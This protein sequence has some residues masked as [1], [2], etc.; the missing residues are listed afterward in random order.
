MVGE[1]GHSKSLAAAAM[2]CQGNGK[3]ANGWAW[4]GVQRPA[5]W[6]SLRRLRRATGA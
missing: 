6:M 4:W 2:D 5:G 1:E 3:T